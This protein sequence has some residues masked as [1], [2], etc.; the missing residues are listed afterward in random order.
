MG[1]TTVD[2]HLY[3]GT[4]HVEGEKAAKGDYPYDAQATLERE[5]G[6]KTCKRCDMHPDA[7]AY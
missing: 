7:W 6:R 1:E 5:R 4:L 2:T 3:W